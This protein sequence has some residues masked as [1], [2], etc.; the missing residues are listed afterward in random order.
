[1]KKILTL[2]LITTAGF[3]FAQSLKSPDEFLGYTLGDRYTR[4]HEMIDYFR[5]VDAQMPNVQITQY[6]KTY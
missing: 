1:M 4:H 3:T 5:Y 2:L 6:G